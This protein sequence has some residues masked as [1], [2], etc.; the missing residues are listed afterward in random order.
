MS[1]AETWTVLR[2]LTWTTH[3]LKQHGSE[4]PRL[5]AEVLLAHARGCERIMLYTR[6]EEEPNDAWGEML[7]YEFPNTKGGNSDKPAIWSSGA[8][9][10]NEDG[11][12]DDIANWNQNQN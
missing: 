12:G 4:S 9:R 10:Q 7:Y 11:G 2:L 6:F 5:E 1:Q 8:N 3:Y